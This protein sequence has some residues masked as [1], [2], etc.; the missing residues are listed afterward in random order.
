MMNFL[1]LFTLLP[2]LTQT[3]I[4]CENVAFHMINEIVHTRSKVLTTFVIDIKPYKNFLTKLSNDLD[5]ARTAAHTIDQFYEAPSKQ[6][7][8]SVIAG[9]KA[10]IATLQKDQMNL[11]ESYIDL[12][13]IHTRIQRSLISIIGKSLSFLF[14]TATEA[15]LKVIH[16]NIDKLA[17]NQEEMAHVID[18]NISVINITMV[19]MS[20]NRQTLNKIIGSLTALDTKL[21]NITQALEREVFKVGQ[22]VQLYLQLESVIQAVRRTIW[23]AGSYLDHIQLQ[24]NMLPLG[25]PSPLVITPRGLKKLLTEIKGHLPEFLSLPYDPRGKIWKFYQTHTCTTVIDQGQFLIIVSIPLLDKNNKYEIY[26]M[27]NMPVPLR[28]S[29]VPKD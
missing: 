15:D 4:V 28:D 14:G 27:F 1:V 13:A 20:Q 10:E 21:G 18:E 7:F 3:L 17:K 9:F 23:Q 25:H 11:V 22:F 26:S 5:K 2:E 24:L 6:D 29:L 8:R 16:N 19:E 12:H